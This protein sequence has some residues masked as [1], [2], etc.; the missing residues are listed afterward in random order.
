M[1]VLAIVPIKMICA[2]A[3]LCQDCRDSLTTRSSSISTG[4]LTVTPLRQRF[5]EDLRLRNRSPKTIEAYV[6]HV[7]ELARYFNQSPEQLGDDQIHRFLLHD[8][9]RD[10]TV[11]M[12]L[13]TIYATGLRISEALHL[14]APQIDS[15]RM[16]VRVLGKG[17]EERL[18]PLSPRRLEE[19]RAFWHETRPTQWMFPGEAEGDI[20][21]CESVLGRM[22]S[23]S[24]S[25]YSPHSMRAIHYV[26]LRPSNVKPG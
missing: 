16:V 2:R 24:V 12:A 18:V 3:F 10:R 19:L 20:V 11:Q 26:P 17:Q 25:S 15:S 9:V 1:P 23:L 8:T 6:Y 7:R 21:N 13:R 4:I 5:I 22:G 14:T